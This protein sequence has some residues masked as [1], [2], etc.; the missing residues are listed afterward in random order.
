VADANQ[1]LNETES[2]M[3]KAIESTKRDFSAVRTGRASTSLV[4]HIKVEYY[5][6][7]VP[8]NQVAN[9]STPDSRTI[10]I[11]PWDANALME[12]DKALQ[13]SDI[14]ISPNNDGKVIRLNI[15]PLTEERRK[16][17]VKMVHKFAEGGRVAIRG[18]RQ[19]ANKSLDHMKKEIAEDEFKKFHDRIQKMTDLHTQEIDK[20]SE[21]KEKEIMEI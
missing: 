21:H 16:E 9:V 10:E 6:S 1:V 12:I 7:L 14:G 5:G 11:K 19:D 8:L 18:I 3:K 20:I 15:P 17:F 13:K 4:E 2:K